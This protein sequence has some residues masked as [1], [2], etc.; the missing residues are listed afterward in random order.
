MKKRRLFAFGCSYTLYI[1]GPTWADFL[2]YEPEL[3]VENWGLPGIG[4]RAIAER[5]AECHAKNTF[6][7][8]DIVIVQWTTHLRHD[9]HNPDWDGGEDNAFR[10][11]WKTGGSLFNTRNSQ[12]YDKK[13][14]QKFFYEPSYIMHCLNH[15]LLTQQMLDN[16]GCTWYMT[17]IGDWQKLST[18]LDD[19]SGTGEIAGRQKSASIKENLPLLMPWVDKIFTDRPDK[20]LEPIGLHAQKTP[21]DYQFFWDFIRMAKTREQHPSPKQYL[22]WLNTNL[23]PVLN[24]KEPIPEIPEKWANSVEFFRKKHYTNQPAFWKAINKIN[25]DQKD[26]WWP[27]DPNIWPSPFIGN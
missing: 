10:M 7:P 3:E 27:D 12:M 23:R 19:I 1:S 25:I 24:L 21:Q 8:D 15:M 16:I 11:H 22:S 13:W 5:V 2:R 6:T 9:F 4:C 20:W 17:S 18:D 26:L 14:L